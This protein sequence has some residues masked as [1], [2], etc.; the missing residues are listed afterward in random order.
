MAANRK[1][2]FRIKTESGGDVGNIVIQARDRYEA[3]SRLR[4]LKKVKE[5]LRCEEK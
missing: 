4:K 2:V 3:E 5:I 1:F